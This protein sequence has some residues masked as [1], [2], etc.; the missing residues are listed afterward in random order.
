MALD[1]HRL[2]ERVLLCIG[3]IAVGGCQG[4]DARP[5]S[6]SL[7]ADR[8]NL[9]VLEQGGVP[10][11]RVGHDESDPI[12]NVKDAR[13]L[14]DR[15]VFSDGTSLRFVA[16]NEGLIQKV[17]RRGE[18]P[19]EFR[20]LTGFDRFGDGFLAWDGF[21][22]RISVLDRHGRYVSSASLIHGGGRIR[23]VG[24][25][26]S[27]ALF[28]VTVSGFPGDGEA[29]PQEVRHD[30][31]FFLVRPRDAEILET[32]AVPST[33]RWSRREARTAAGRNGGLAVLFGRDPV[34]AIAGEAGYIG[35]TG[36]VDFTR[37]DGVGGVTRYLFPHD[38]VAV[39]P[40]WEQMLRDSLKAEIDAIQPG[41]LV[42]ADGV[43]RQLGWKRF[44]LSLLQDLPARSMLP[45]FLELEGDAAG[46]LWLREYSTPGNLGDAVWLV[47]DPESGPVAVARMPP[48]FEILDIANEHIVGLTLGPLGQEIIEVYEIRTGR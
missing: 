45:A 20:N 28:Q 32:W 31:D 1:A 24:A 5:M 42:S 8:D 35:T 37:I 10:V 22:R 4:P 43:N 18:G 13:W 23:L 17:G 29:P 9:Q 6:S 44:R 21:L 19:G 36:G 47:V 34:A 25:V 41:R 7:F 38:T 46:R 26:G 39:E 16:P 11:L 3:L 27:N 15:L 14:G 2:G 48:D 33:P 30:E 40:E 12:H